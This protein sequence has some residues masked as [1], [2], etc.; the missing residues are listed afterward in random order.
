MLPRP[1]PTHIAHLTRGNGAYW[2]NQVRNHVILNGFDAVLAPVRKL[3]E[4]WLDCKPGPS[5]SGGEIASENMETTPPPPLPSPD[6]GDRLPYEIEEFLLDLCDVQTQ[7][8]QHRS[9]GMYSDAEF[10]HL[11]DQCL[12]PEDT[13]PTSAEIGGDAASSGARPAERPANPEDHEASDDAPA[14]MPASSMD[15]SEEDYNSDGQTP[16]KPPK[17]RPQA[18]SAT[19]VR[20]PVDIPRRATRSTAPPT[21]P[22]DLPPCPP[23]L[24]PAFVDNV[25]WII[26]G[27][28][29]PGCF[30][31]REMRTHRNMQRAK[32]TL[33]STLYGTM[34]TTLHGRPYQVY[35]EFGGRV[36]EFLGP[37]ASFRTKESDRLLPSHSKGQNVPLRDNMYASVPLARFPPCPSL[38]SLLMAANDMGPINTIDDQR[39]FDA[40]LAAEYFLDHRA[41]HQRNNPTTSSPSRASTTKDTTSVPDGLSTLSLERQNT[42][43]LSTMFQLMTPTI[44]REFEKFETPAAVFNMISTWDSEKLNS[45]CP[46]IQERLRVA[47]MSGTETVDEFFWRVKDM[48]IELQKAGAPV[49]QNYALGI[50]VNG[51]RQPRFEHLRIRYAEKRLARVPLDYWVVLKDYHDLDRMNMELP[52]TDPRHPEYASKPILPANSALTLPHTQRPKGRQGP[53]QPFEPCTWGPCQRKKSH[54]THKC[55]LKNPSLK[56]R[57]PRD[58]VVPA[59]LS[60]PS[61]MTRQQNATVQALLDSYALQGK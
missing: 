56:K 7:M 59:N 43:I 54:P 57:L 42:V 31:M 24:P 13:P 60:V 4:S 36:R 28:D 17:A 3:P 39:M 48:C 5:Y 2:T 32:P 40:G 14:E 29:A 35:S 1:A 20:A 41:A 51:I 38:T 37:P 34:K 46:K 6:V 55:W 15:G 53:S 44:L 18:S 61:N 21:P 58:E 22:E 33:D 9:M 49:E 50:I 45:D 26:T 30:R 52:T 47:T 16:V 23:P 25:S 19:T 8:L 11:P 10:H 27:D 12:S